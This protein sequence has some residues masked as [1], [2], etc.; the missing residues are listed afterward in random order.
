MATYTTRYDDQVTITHRTGTYYSEA[1]LYT[2]IEAHDEEGTAISALYADPT[3]GQIMQVET[4]EDRQGEGIATLLV[5]YAVD[6]GIDLYHS[7][8]AHCTEAGLRF[9]EAT[10]HLIDEIDEETAFAA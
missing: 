6:N 9:R 3:T 10:S 4:M 5:E 8:E 7:P 2:I 1:S